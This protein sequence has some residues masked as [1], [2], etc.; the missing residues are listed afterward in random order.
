MEYCRVKIP[1]ANKNFLAI[2]NAST[3]DS[4]TYKCIASNI[5]SSVDIQFTV[6]VLGEFKID[7]MFK[8]RFFHMEFYPLSRCIYSVYNI[9]FDNQLNRS[10]FNIMRSIWNSSSRFNVD[11]CQSNFVIII[12][13]QYV[14]GRSNKCEHK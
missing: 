7:S 1:D 3:N 2:Q 6:N 10:D 9:K 14:T 8:K 13:V 4:G 12:E 11:L 5:V